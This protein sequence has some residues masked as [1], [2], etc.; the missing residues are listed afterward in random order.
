MDKNS[1]NYMTNIQMKRAHSESDDNQINL[2]SATYL[3]P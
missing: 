2:I 1:A 3:N